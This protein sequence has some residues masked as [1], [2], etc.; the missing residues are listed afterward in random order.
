MKADLPTY[1][2]APVAVTMMV[3]FRRPGTAPRESRLCV[4]FGL[5]QK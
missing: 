4:C 2:V 1:A 5:Y 3:I